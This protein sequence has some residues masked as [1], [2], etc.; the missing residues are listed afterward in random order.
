MYHMFTKED[1]DVKHFVT[2]RDYIVVEQIEQISNVMNNSLPKDAEKSSH[3]TLPAN[4]GG[5]HL[6]NCQLR[7]DVANSP[8]T[9]SQ[10]LTIN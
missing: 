1:K 2:L 3:A 4:N 5:C 8:L 10:S 9:A 7:P 6:G